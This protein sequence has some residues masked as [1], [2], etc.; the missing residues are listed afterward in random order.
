M[1]RKLKD[2]TGRCLGDESLGGARHSVR[3]VDR[4]SIKGAHRVT[5]PTFGFSLIEMLITLALIL[6]MSVMLMGRGSKS[7]QQRDILACQKNLQTVHTAL[8]IYSADNG[9]FPVSTNA[10]T[11]EAPL[12]LLIPRCTTETGVFIC[13]GTPD[14]VL[15]QGE[16]FEKRKISYAYYMGWPANASPSTPIA[17]DR[18]VNL[19]P[20]KTGELV[21]SADGKAPGGNHHK[22]GGNV[23]FLSGEAQKSKSK[24][25]FDLLFPTNVSLLNPRP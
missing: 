4:R 18:Q 20:K 10:Q 8:T 25:A 23:L 2:E 21:F 16:S 12:S 3:A 24:S 9:C 5:R 14:P 17:S 7:R 22:Y 19:N 11:S 15:P 6:I 13:P 1:T